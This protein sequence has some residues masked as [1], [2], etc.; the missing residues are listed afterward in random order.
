M[1]NRRGRNRSW[2][3]R[4]SGKPYGK[5]PVSTKPYDEDPPLNPKCLTGQQLQD[6]IDNNRARI[7]EARAEMTRRTDKVLAKRLELLESEL[8]QT[9]AKLNGTHHSTNAQSGMDYTQQ[10][11]LRMK[12]FTDILQ[13]MYRAIAEYRHHRHD[14]AE[15][16]RS[17][18]RRYDQRSTQRRYPK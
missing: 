13:S 4:N 5:K 3:N 2:H 17:T 12:E 14:C 9:K 7:D 16:Q 11:E 8:A 15:P 1:S 18:Q 10:L 6:A